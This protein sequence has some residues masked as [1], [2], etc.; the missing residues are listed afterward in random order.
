MIGRVTLREMAMNIGVQMFAMQAA[1]VTFLPV[2]AL[3][4]ELQ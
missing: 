2:T 3:I 4:G 1:V